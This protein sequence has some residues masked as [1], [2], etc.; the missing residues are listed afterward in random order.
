MNWRISGRL[1]DEAT[2]DGVLGAHDA[3]RAWPP[4]SDGAGRDKIVWMTA[5]VVVAE[6]T[7]YPVKSCAG[8]SLPRAHV[9]PMGIRYDRQWMVVDE[10]GR[11]MAQRTD[12]E[13]HGAGCRSLAGVATDISDDQLLLNAAGMPPLAVPL[14]GRDGPRMRVRVWN[15]HTVGVDQGTAAADWF[16]EYLSRERPGRYR[17]VRMPED[18]VR[19]A[20]RG[21]GRLAF[22][23]GYPF[24][25]ISTA[26]LADL[27][28]R[29]AAPLPMG[30]FRPSLVI[31]TDEP[32]AE[33]RIE[34]AHI[35]PVELF[36]TTR[37]VRCPIPT[38]DQQTG[39]RGKEPL[40]TLATYRRTP[41][42]VVFGRNFNHAGTGEIAVGERVEILAW[43][44]DSA[45]PMPA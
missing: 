27:N 22:A 2:R 37:C 19:P 25:V 36:G 4:R 32:Y 13:R 42:G 34:H 23:D 20:N 11:F 31:R 24:M 28:R 12:D 21:S 16:S 9:G 10:A 3:G 1:P 17:L 8:L 38:F 15:M 41:R 35:G 6:L 29:M 26:S 7:C 43:Q 30:R 40:R 33:D 44:T 18:E 14:A 39:A 5:D 45:E